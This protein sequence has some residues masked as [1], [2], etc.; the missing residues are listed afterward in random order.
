M[1]ESQL[2]EQKINNLGKAK[3]TSFPLVN[4]LEV[5]KKNSAKLELKKLNHKTLQ[6]KNILSKNSNVFP[7][8]PLSTHLNHI[9]EQEP[10]DNNI[11]TKK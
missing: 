7:T 6:K 10:I 3:P 11:Q 1:R 2:K 8:V 5:A 9:E 4:A